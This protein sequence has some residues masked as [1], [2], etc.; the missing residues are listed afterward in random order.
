MHKKRELTIFEGGGGRI[1]QVERAK[2]GPGKQSLNWG[3]S[4]FGE[5]GTHFRETQLLAVEVGLVG[6][7][8]RKPERDW[9]GKY[10]HSGK[11]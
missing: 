2:R 4:S 5:K 7:Y 9:E 11:N 10:F 6:D 1:W 3:R 8:P